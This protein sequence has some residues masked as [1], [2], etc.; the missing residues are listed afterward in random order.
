ML[1]AVRICCHSYDKLFV[2]E[3][4]PTENYSFSEEKK[5]VTDLYASQRKVI[6]KFDN[7]KEQ[8]VPLADY[9]YARASEDCIAGALT[10]SKTRKCRLHDMMTLD[11][12]STKGTIPSIFSSGDLEGHGTGC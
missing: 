10:K 1:E 12:L 6:E 11:E 5:E 2:F 3:P 8:I 4:H 9:D 7:W